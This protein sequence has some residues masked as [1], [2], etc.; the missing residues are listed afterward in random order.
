MSRRV[1]AAIDADALVKVK[2][3]QG[4]EDRDKP[5]ADYA[6]VANFLRGGL[7]DPR[8]IVALMLRLKCLQACQNADAIH[9][10][11][12]RAI[13]AGFD[14]NDLFFALRRLPRRRTEGRQARPPG[15]ARAAAC[16]DA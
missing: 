5:N 3:G 8:R 16:S 9:D 4:Q 7:A 6:H 14:D 15:G 1:R 12:S 13:T 10:I 11:G 2:A